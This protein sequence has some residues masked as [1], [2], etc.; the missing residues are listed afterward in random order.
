MGRNVEFAG[1]LFV[2]TAIQ[3]GKMKNVKLGII[4]VLNVLK[5]QR[6][7]TKAT[8]PTAEQE[9]MVTAMNE[10]PCRTCEKDTYCPCPCPK[11]KKWFAA[12]WRRLREL[13]LGGKGK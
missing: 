9:W 6:T 4:C 2:C 7:H 8:A 12:E 10:C 3:D 13:F 5:P 11:Q 1:S